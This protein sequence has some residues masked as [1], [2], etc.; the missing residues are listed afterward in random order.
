MRV[1]ILVLKVCSASSRNCRRKKSPTCIALCATEVL[2]QTEYVF[3]E[4][5]LS[6]L[7]VRCVRPHPTLH[8]LHLKAM[9]AVCALPYKLSG[10]ARMLVLLVGCVL[11]QPCVT[12]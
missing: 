2:H 4:Q 1:Y 10:S 5:S 3:L 9:Q 7:G 6:D 12:M 8:E 11:S